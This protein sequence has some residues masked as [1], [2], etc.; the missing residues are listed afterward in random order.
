MLL[1]GA[2]EFSAHFKYNLSPGFLHSII[3]CL[4]LPSF[5]YTKGVSVCTYSF[6]AIPTRLRALKKGEVFFPRRELNKLFCVVLPEAY[7]YYNLEIRVNV[8]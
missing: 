5:P 4:G 6:T 3:C 1:K 8:N 7:P 2:W